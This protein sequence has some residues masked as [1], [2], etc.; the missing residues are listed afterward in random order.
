[1]K[2]ELRAKIIVYNKAAAERKEKAADLDTIVTAIM[3][4]SPGQLK[5]V[6]SDEVLAV[7]GKYGVNLDA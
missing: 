2:P 1:M 6:L 3:K 7:F 5:K 4:L